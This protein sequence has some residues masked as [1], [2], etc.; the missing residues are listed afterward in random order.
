MEKPCSSGFYLRTRKKSSFLTSR[1]SFLWKNRVL[2]VSGRNTLENAYKITSKSKFST[3]FVQF[4]SHL[5]PALSNSLVFVCIVCILPRI[6]DGINF[7][8]Y[9]TCVLAI[10]LNRRWFGWRFLLRVSI[11]F[12]WIDTSPLSI[13]LHIQTHT[14]GLQDDG[15]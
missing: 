11:S 2:Q 9:F 14:Q 4:S 8:E 5:H 13:E 15:T 6:R 12:S 1:Q 7:K 10:Y 3:H